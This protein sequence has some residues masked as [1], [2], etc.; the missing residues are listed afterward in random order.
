MRNGQIWISKINNVQHEIISSTPTEVTVK[1]SNERVYRLNKIIF[2]MQFYPLEEN[3]TQRINRKL[4]KYRM[5]GWTQKD[6]QQ[7][8]AAVAGV[9]VCVAVLFHMIFFQ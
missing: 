9:V 8:L 5:Q 1:A 6:R 3:L 7:I 2:S 4:T